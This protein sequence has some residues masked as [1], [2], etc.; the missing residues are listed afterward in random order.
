LIQSDQ[1][2]LTCK[3]GVADPSIYERK[4]LLGGM[5]ASEARRLRTLADEDTR[6]KRLFDRRR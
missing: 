3:P 1:I 5:D 2:G 4:I 6:L